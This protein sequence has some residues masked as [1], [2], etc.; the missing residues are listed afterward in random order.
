MAPSNNTIVSNIIDKIHG[1]GY[2]TESG[3]LVK[4]VGLEM[5]RQDIGGLGRI[6]TE[7]IGSQKEQGDHL[8]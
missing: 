6:E 4:D 2:Y 8:N 5:M 3:V 7:V 1:L